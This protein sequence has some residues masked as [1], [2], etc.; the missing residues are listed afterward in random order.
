METDSSDSIRQPD[1][2]SEFRL[3]GDSDRL[4]P[5]CTVRNSSSLAATVMLVDYVRT[6]GTNETSHIEDVYQ[7]LTAQATRIPTM[8]QQFDQL[9][10]VR[11]NRR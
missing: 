11:E 4:I 5:T 3:L 2:T 7:Q 9:N 8:Q 1:L 10:A 6:N